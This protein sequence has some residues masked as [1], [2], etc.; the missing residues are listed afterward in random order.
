MTI[1]WTHASLF[2]HTGLLTFFGFASNPCSELQ[3]SAEHGT[4]EREASDCHH[5]L[6]RL[7]LHFGLKALVPLQSIWK[8]LPAAVATAS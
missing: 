8:W 3:P 5:S 4:N 2:H 1:P 6:A 7:S